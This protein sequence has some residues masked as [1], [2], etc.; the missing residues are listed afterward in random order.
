MKKFLPIIIFSF[1]VFSFSCKS[2]NNFVPGQKR[3][4]I[5]NLYKEYYNIAETYFSLKN[6][7]KAISYYKICLE[8]KDLYNASY[9]KLGLS[10]VMNNDWTNAEKIF[11][12]LYKKDFEN[13]AIKSSLAYI[14][15]MSGNL[16][17][18]EQFYSEIVKDKPDS[19]EYLEN[20][21][22]ILIKNE[23]YQLAEE[24]FS[25]L[26]E[27]FPNSLK[28]ADIEKKFEEINSEKKSNETEENLTEQIE[29][30][31]K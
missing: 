23:K 29:N 31:E 12:E 10:Y 4:Q 26:K 21:I 25:L 2:V 19:S 5:N 8:N 18:A 14:Y 22:A 20:Y 6:Y 7:T 3:I 28:I 16:T 30:I 24:Q 17:K 15:S 9:Y 11:T 13:D 1:C 27:K